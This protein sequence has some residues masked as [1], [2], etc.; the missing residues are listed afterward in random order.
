MRRRTF[1]RH[2]SITTEQVYKCLTFYGMSE[3]AVLAQ[4]PQLTPEDLV[5][6]EDTIVAEIRRIDRDEW[7]GR[8]I[9]PKPT[10]TDGGYYK[11]R[12]RNATVARWNAKENCFYHWR[13]KLGAIFLETIRYPTDEEPWFDVFYPVEPLRT[14]QFEIPFEK[15]ARFEGKTEDLYR[16]T[17]EM[18]SK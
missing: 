2:T 10:L 14:C 8:P 17:E 7:T 1:L 16:F 18:W 4:Y 3:E 6:I 11:G 13:E 15:H 9:L 12:C 5:G